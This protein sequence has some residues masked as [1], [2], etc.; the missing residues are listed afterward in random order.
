MEMNNNKPKEDI[1][2]PIDNSQLFYK[3]AMDKGKFVSGM[4]N[5]S[6]IDRKQCV[7]NIALALKNAPQPWGRVSDINSF[8]S[9]QQL[10]LNIQLLY[11]I[12]QAAD[13]DS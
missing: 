13:Q 3:D 10:T 6:P 9:S 2:E 5:T 7:S 12:N 8:N 11:N 1:R 4:T